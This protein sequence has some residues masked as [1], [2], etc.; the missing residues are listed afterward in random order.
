[1]VFIVIFQNIN[2]SEMSSFSSTFQYVISELNSIQKCNED[3]RIIIH[4][5]VRPFITKKKIKELLN[6]SSKYPGLVPGLKVHD[7]IKKVDDKNYISESVKRENIWRIQ[8]PQ[9]FRYEILMKSFEH[10]LKTKFTGTDESSIVTNAGYKVKIVDG[11]ISN[12]K[13]TTKEDLKIVDF[14]KLLIS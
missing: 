11:E 6:L 7:T 3:D 14:N 5:A 12:L 2:L 10:A 9:I 13:I 8:T 4:D 1:M